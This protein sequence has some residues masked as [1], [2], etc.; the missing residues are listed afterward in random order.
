MK[1]TIK[2]LHLDNNHPLMM[3]QLQE[4]AF[5]NHEDFISTKNEIEEKIYFL[6]NSYMP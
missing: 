6:T 4:A 1:Q 3:A 2:I 5:I